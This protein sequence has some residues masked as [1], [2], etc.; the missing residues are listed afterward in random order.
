[1]NHMSRIVI[2][3]V[4]MI[5][6]LPHSHALANTASI[7]AN[8]YSLSLDVGYTSAGSLIYF[9]TYDGSAGFPVHDTVGGYYVFNG[10]LKPTSPGSGTYRGDYV[11][12]DSYNGIYEYGNYTLTFPTT[13][14]D[15]NGCPDILQPDKA[16]NSAL[17]GTAHSDWRLDG[18]TL[19][20]TASGPFRRTAGSD[21]GTYS[22]TLSY[23]SQSVTADGTM[24]LSHWNGTVSYTPWSPTLALTI[25]LVQPDGDRRTL[26]GTTSYAINSANQ[27]SIAACVLSDELSRSYSVGA[28]TMQRSG[29][30]YRGNATL[31][32]GNKETSWGD[33]RD[34]WVEIVDA[35]DANGNGIPDLSDPVA[36]RV[37]GLSGNLAFGGVQ[38]GTTASRT[39]T[40]S[41]T[42][43]S[44]LT[45]NSISY[46][47]GFSGAWSGS[48]AAG[49]S[50]NVIV[51]FAPTSMGSYGG[52]ISIDSD[53]TSGTSTL[54][55]S[56]TGS[57]IYT[58]SATSA[59]I[60][61][62]R[63][64]DSITIY[65]GSGCAWTATS[66]ASWI[67]A[68]SNGTGDGTLS[69]AVDANFGVA[70]SGIITVQ[71]QVFTI[72]QAE[73]ILSSIGNTPVV[74]VGDTVF[75]GPGLFGI[76]T[77]PASCLWDFGDGQTSI[78]CE[79]SHVF[80]HCGPII[81]TY[82]A[83]E[84][85]SSLTYAFVVS[86]ACPFD[87][88]LKPVALSVKSNFAP[89][90]LDT[91]S[92][93]GVLNLPV[94]ITMTNFAA[95]LSIGSVE[96]PFTLDGKGKGVS[97]NAVTGVSSVKFSRKGKPVGSNQLW[98]VSAKFKGDFDALWAADGLANT[99]VL[100][101]P[102]T[103]PVLLLLDT[104]PPES[105]YI[106]KPVLYNAT[107]DKS[108]SAK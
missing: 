60:A 39:L 19:N 93:K 29:N 28:F 76:A 14:S 69:Y 104:E 59:S 71:G 100:N 79:P 23:G 74:A 62:G 2:A 3:S 65:A 44:P 26:S 36:T 83:T 56:G 85:V 95:Q 108:G 84:G 103:V 78:D 31:V 15:G 5:C 53:A 87:E 35:N 64:N 10:E 101:Q 48:I 55:A 70:R 24:Y 50:H 16:V 63:T 94:G 47:T 9:T 12:W 27:I 40:I 97:G 11:A 91:A 66:S 13:D 20:Y 51:T 32:D 46:P 82:I 89:G 57:C 37:I 107:Q 102:L 4:A 8:N 75:F 106:E 33:Y 88:S 92:L 96:I 105:F 22:L 61:A 18:Y 45:V 25:T 68:S 34:C 90:K 86:V 7:S 30:R 99:N 1:M 72:H 58:L 42:G 80:S 81:V 43:N 77:N 52:M 41:N 54:L 98:Q 21:T 73:N 17:T 38:I 49:G 6:L 67:H